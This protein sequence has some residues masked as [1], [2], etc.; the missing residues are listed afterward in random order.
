VEQP[1]TD[2]RLANRAAVACLV[3]LAVDVLLV[4]AIAVSGRDFDWKHD[5]M[6]DM[7]WLLA[8][9]AAVLLLAAAGCWLISGWRTLR[10]A[11][12]LRR[13]HAGRYVSADELT[14]LRDN[15]ST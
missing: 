4:P 7:L 8:G 12:V 5:R 14:E 2:S 1:V 6:G 9:Q 3:L 10:R 13:H 11:P 15:R